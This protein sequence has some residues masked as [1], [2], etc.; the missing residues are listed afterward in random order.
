MASPGERLGPDVGI[1]DGAGERLGVVEVTG[2]G[3]RDNQLANARARTSGSVMVRA[4]ASAS[5]TS[6]PARSR[7]P[8]CSDRDSHLGER[9]GPDV[10]VA[11][12]AGRRLG[13]VQVTGLRRSR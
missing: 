5:A 13:A 9:P 11:D 4:S 1:G 12:G 3:D 2:L 7:S 6:R 8:A 10:G